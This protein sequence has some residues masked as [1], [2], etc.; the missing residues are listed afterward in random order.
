[1]VKHGE[2][3]RLLDSHGF[4]GLRES[5]GDESFRF[6][7]T[8]VHQDRGVRVVISA[9][10]AFRR[11]Q[12]GYGKPLNRRLVLV[13]LLDGAC[14]KIPGARSPVPVNRLCEIERVL[15]AVANGAYSHNMSN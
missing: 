8:A 11:H 4:D 15:R 7:I 6:K 3:K 13:E 12:A 5:L 2:V 9:P 14:R 10:N 1:M